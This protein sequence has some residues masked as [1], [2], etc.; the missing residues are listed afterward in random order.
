MRVSSRSCRLA[1]AV[2]MAG[3][4][5]QRVAAQEAAESHFQ[6]GY[7]L[8]TLKSDPAGAA[9][10]FEQVLADSSASAEIKAQAQTRLAECREDLA[11]ADLAQLLPA[12]ALAYLEVNRPGAHVGN[13]IRMFG[14]MPAST[15]G[16]KPA[17]AKAEPAS[18]IPLAPG[19]IVPG[20]F[21]VS[22]ALVRELEKV[23]GVAVAI[24]SINQDGIPDGVAVIHPGESDLLRGLAET[25]IQFVERS[26][27]IEGFKTY[28]IENEVYLVQTSRLF[29][30]AGS[31]DQAV[32][33]IA[34]LKNS[35]AESLASNKRFAKLAA[36]RKNSLAFAYLAG[37]QIAPLM[38]A[39]GA[40]TE[41]MIAR[42]VVDLDKL[43]SVV[44]VTKTTDDG[45]ELQGKM[46]MAEGHKNLAYALIRTAPTSRRTL[47][48]VPSGAAAVGILGLNPATAAGEVP[49]AKPGEP[50]YV[51]AM[52]LGREVFANIEEV[53]VFVMPST[54]TDA[55]TPIPEVGLVFGVKDAEQSQALWD[56]LLALPSMFGAPLTSPP[57]DVT[58]EGQKAR[59]FRFPYIPPVVLVAQKDRTFL[60][61]TQGAVAASLRVAAGKQDGL[62]KDAQLKPLVDALPKHTSKGAVVHVGRTIRLATP[63]AG[64]EMPEELALSTSVLDS[65]TLSIVTDEQPTEFAIRAEAK[66]MPDITQL[67][68]LAAQFDDSRRSRIIEARR[69]IEAAR[70]DA[71]RADAEVR[72]LREREAKYDPGRLPPREA[73]S[74]IDSAVKA[75]RERIAEESTR[76]T[77]PQ[78]EVPR[79]ELVPAA[80]QR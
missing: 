60:A 49:A 65:L 75:E 10:A 29:I 43:E 20:D 63:I 2:A 4:L 33:A 44:A 66:G 38:I 51:S 9:K 79:T 56:Q 6:R 19:F 59:Q 35:G 46:V 11:A 72:V 23:R 26:E 73:T 70:V 74:A 8:Q 5:V 50:R 12:D 15:G 36:D 16:E 41:A 64:D 47:A 76:L 40:F 14:L 28:Q 68:K 58:I 22:P 17:N 27:A 34:R 1:L 21:A 80:P 3:M 54:N 78:V 67:V 39:H 7:Y 30:V 55:R 42:S 13:V 62:D 57:T 77:P 69:Q 48:S 52:D 45:I 32:A 61:G 37:D 53:S 25:S 24:T 18:G 71:I 31:K